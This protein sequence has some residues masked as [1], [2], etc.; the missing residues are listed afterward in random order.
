MLYLNYSQNWA[1]HVDL[2]TGALFILL[3]SVWAAQMCF[4][5]ICT[6]ELVTS[7]REGASHCAAHTTSA[8]CSSYCVCRFSHF[9]CVDS[10]RPHRL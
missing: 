5:E 4:H 1:F 8:Q 3:G 7:R 9:G 10:L 6:S 2:G